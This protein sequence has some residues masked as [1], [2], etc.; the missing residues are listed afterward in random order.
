[1]ERRL[2]FWEWAGFALTAL[3]APLTARLY[4]W[5]GGAPLA[6]AFFPVNGSVWEAMKALYLPVFLF[7]MVQFWA[8]GREYPGL[9]SVRAVSALAGLAL[10]PVLRYTYAGALGFR[11]LWADRAAF[12]LA[13]LGLFCLD[14]RLLRRSRRTAVWRQ[15]LGMLVLWGLVFLFV[16]HTFR[17]PRLAL[18][19]DPA[20][21]I[22]GWG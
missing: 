19:Q 17:P 11:L 9:P 3:L 7:S 2:F 15:V 6:G 13:D 5:S 21:G 16:F 14:L 4:G 10:L 18:W 8:M 20:S 1:M 12:L 22:P